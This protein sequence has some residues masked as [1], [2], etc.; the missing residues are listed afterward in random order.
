MLIKKKGRV[1]YFICLA[2]DCEF[3]V[4]IHAVENDDGNFYRKCPMCGADCHTDYSK[5]KG[6]TAE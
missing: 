2:C 1:L 3:V 5:Q 6:D 4:G